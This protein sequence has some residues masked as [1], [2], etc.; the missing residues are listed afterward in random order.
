MATKKKKKSSRKKLFG[1]AL[2][3]HQRKLARGGSAKGHKSGQ[4]RMSRIESDYW[5][6]VKAMRE[7][8]L[9]PRGDEREVRVV[10][11]RVVYGYKKR[12]VPRARESVLSRLVMPTKRQRTFV[13]MRQRNVSANSSGTTWCDSSASRRLAICGTKPKSARDCARS[14]ATLANRRHNPSLI[15]QRLANG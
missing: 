14:R 11:G 1:A 10:G 4:S 13:L 2:A 5:T 3:A 7:A 8:G 6:A 15:R 9:H 12:A